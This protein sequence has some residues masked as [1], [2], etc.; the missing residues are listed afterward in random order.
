MHQKKKRISVDIIEIPLM[1]PN[2][3]HWKYISPLQHLSFNSCLLSS[4]NI[5]LNWHYL[6]NGI[7][8]VGKIFNIEDKQG[9]T[10]N[11]GELQF[12]VLLTILLVKKKMQFMCEW[13]LMEVSKHHQVFPQPPKYFLFRTQIIGMGSLP[14]VHTT[15]NALAKEHSGNLRY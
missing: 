15:Y 14:L 1:E 8:N 3:H 4:H 11:E 12:L 6:L 7:I 10:L 9:V 2:L 5:Q 13:A